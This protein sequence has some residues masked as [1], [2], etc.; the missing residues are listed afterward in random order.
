VTY[1]GWKNAYSF[2]L[3]GKKVNLLA[4]SS[5]QVREDQL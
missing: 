1:N 2:M 5:L 3:D 4:L